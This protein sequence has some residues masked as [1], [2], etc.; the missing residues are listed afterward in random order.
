MEKNIENLASYGLRIIEDIKSRQ[1]GLDYLRQII[2]NIDNS[3]KILKKNLDDINQKKLSL[4]NDHEVLKKVNVELKNKYDKLEND[5]DEL[6][7]E[8]E[9]LENENYELRSSCDELKKENEILKKELSLKSEQITNLNCLLKEK[10]NTIN[11]LDCSL[12]EEKNKNEEKN[13]KINSLKAQISGLQSDKEQGKVINEYLEKIR[14]I[15]NSLNYLFKNI[16]NEV[17]ES[18][19]EEDNKNYLPECCDY[20]SQNEASGNNGQEDTCGM[21]DKSN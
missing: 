9:V 15:E 16:K 10:D 18:N 2:E 1:E 6:E 20:K 8:Y 5:Y 19:K 4:E 14:N 7:N 12:V 3:N 17:K 13:E 11:K 21:T